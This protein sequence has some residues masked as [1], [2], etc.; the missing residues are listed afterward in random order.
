MEKIL[1]IGLIIGIPANLFIAAS[2]MTGH[3]LPKLLMKTF[4]ITSILTALIIG[5]MLAGLIKS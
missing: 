2:N 4:A 3:W 1:L 5:F